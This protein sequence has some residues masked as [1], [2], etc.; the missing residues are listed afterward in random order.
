[1]G[2]I[3]KSP[4]IWIGYLRRLPFGSIKGGCGIGVLPDSQP[5]KSKPLT[6]LKSPQG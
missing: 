6:L 3:W 5:F 1:M 4:Y 2:A